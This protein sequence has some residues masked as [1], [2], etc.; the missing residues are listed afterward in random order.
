MSTATKPISQLPTEPANRRP[1]MPA[2]VGGL[3][4]LAIVLAFWAPW[5]GVGET[6]PV[7]IGNQYMEARNAFDAEKA[8]ALMSADASVLDVPRME[9]DELAAGFAVLKVYEASFD[10]YTCT[11]E[12]GTT[13]VTCNY[14]F[15]T[16]LSRIVGHGPVEGSI[17]LLVENGVITSLV[18]SF[19]FDEYAPNVFEK[20]A[21]WLGTEHP[22]EFDQVYADNGG[23]LSPITTPEALAALQGY[24]E[25]YDRFLNG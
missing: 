7:D 11:N 9:R 22:N 23:V 8:G 3:I 10:P 18:H 25:E 17:R 2:V 15:E 19:N 5:A 1:W 16:N 12:P 14:S 6:I 13:L 4:A 21:V 24:I 20:F